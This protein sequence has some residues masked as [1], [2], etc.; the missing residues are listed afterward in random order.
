M[1]SFVFVLSAGLMA[2]LL[3]TGPAK[4]LI[5]NPG[6]GLR[7]NEAVGL[8]R[9]HCRKYWHCHDRWGCHRC[10]DSYHHRHGKHRHRWW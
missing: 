4:A 2:M 5:G 1:R 6:S 8:T 9:V 7:S 3:V 10:G